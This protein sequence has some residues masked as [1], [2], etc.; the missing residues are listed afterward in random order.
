M[1]EPAL[2]PGICS[3]IGTRGEVEGGGGEVDG[4]V[5]E[6]VRRLS[7]GR[8]AGRRVLSRAVRQTRP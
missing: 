5:H 4:G 2:M 1:Q 3:R 6:R 7:R 8:V